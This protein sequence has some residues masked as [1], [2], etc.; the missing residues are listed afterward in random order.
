MDQNEHAM[1]VNV[2]SEVNI[3][4]ADDSLHVAQLI[5]SLGGC[6][7]RYQRRRKKASRAMLAE[8]YSPPRITAGATQLLHLGCI[9]GVAFDLTIVDEHGKPC[10]LDDA[11]QRQRAW[12]IFAKEKLARVIGTSMCRAFSAWQRI[13]NQYCDPKAIS[14]EYARALVHFH[15]CKQICQHQV[16]NGRYFLHEN[17]IMLCHEMMHV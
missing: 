10:G 7:R 8:L 2:V 13:N 4:I 17:K 16:D 15:L 14:R 3:I 11:D 12:S 5:H 1:D 9:P 6:N